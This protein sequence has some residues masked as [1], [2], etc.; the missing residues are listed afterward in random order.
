M[1][2]MRNALAVLSVFALL[3]VACGDDEP[4]APIET[5]PPVTVIDTSAQEAAEAAEDAANAALADAEAELEA[6]QAALAEAE[7]AAEE[8]GEEAQMALEEAQKTAEAAQMGLD[9]AQK[10]AEEAQMAAEEAQMA[11]EAAQMALEEAGKGPGAGVSVTMAR[12]NW[13]TG[14]LQ[15]AIYA[16][17]LAELGY[18]VSDP[19]DLELAPSNAFVAMANG[20]FD[21]WVNSWFPNHN[22]FLAAAMPDGSLVSEHVTSLGREMARSGVQGLITNKAFAD[23]H[24]L[25]TL[26]ALLA[27]PDQFAVYE[28]ADPSPGDGILQIYGCPDGWGCHVNINSWIENAGWGNIEQ[29]DVGGYD[30]MITDAIA[31]DGA[32]EPYLVYTWAPSHYVSDLRPGDNAVWVSIHEDQSISPTQIEGPSSLGDR[33]TADPCLLGWDAADI[34]VTANNAF[35]AANPAAARLFELFTINPVDVALQNVR[36]QGGE[37]TEEDIKRHAAEWITDNRATVDVWLAIASVPVDETPGSGVPV[38]MAR[39]NWS[40]GYL[41]A[42]IYAALLAELGYEVSDPE[43][44]ELA[45]SNAFVAMANGEFDFWVNSWFPN[46]NQFL[47]AAMPD[48]SLVSEHVTSLGREMARSGVQG[49]ITNKAF[50]DEH[51]LTTLD[52]LLANPDQF[53][54]YEAADPSPGDGILQIYG[55]PDGWGCHVNINSWIE[56][57]GWGNIEQFDV[58][59]YDAMITDAI[60]R[61]GA[62]EPYLVYTWAPSHYVSDLRPGDNA[63]WVSIHEDQSISPTQIE[64]PSSLGD[65]CTADPCLLGWDAADIRVTANNAFL[66]A[67][68]A[69]ARLF[70]L[71]TI[72]PVDVALQN[73]RM[74]GGEAT[75]EDI[76]RHAAEWITEN[77]D[78][79]DSWLRAARL[80]G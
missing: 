74:Q 25:T 33:C 26:D 5:Q 10:T 53:A 18:E 14:Y 23:E 50:A 71:F 6:A 39:A 58:G 11:A 8:G 47:A 36:M 49:L 38:T 78:L 63:V 16:A 52:A 37:A 70:E 65:R 29:F 66:A 9:E 44:L 13:S 1:T 15:A 28:A 80:T 35:L 77:R 51:G 27:N 40:T 32:G 75:E 30:A 22:Q 56:N 76:K 12:A 17:L 68:P 4:A 31:R 48:G 19:E 42:A 21:F 2:R 72:N 59:G 20:E 7:A 3:A 46:H 61:D 43:D 60:A 73:V 41:Q 64:G 24:G 79:A 45:P 62:G 54:V 55:C 57:A 34:R 69:A 67:N